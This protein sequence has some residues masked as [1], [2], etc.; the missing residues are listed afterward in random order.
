MEID[1]LISVFKASKN[2]FDNV[3]DESLHWLRFHIE[4]KDNF[5]KHSSIENFRKTLSLGR[6]D[7][8]FRKCGNWFSL[9]IKVLQRWK[10]GRK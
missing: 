5:T 10:F 9:W 7:S 1:R 4:N 6:D 3:E 2:D 8:M